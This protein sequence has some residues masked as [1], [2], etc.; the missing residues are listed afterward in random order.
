[1]TEP[2]VASEH[3]TVLAHA[4]MG[5]A[6]ERG[7]LAS[8]PVKIDVEAFIGNLA[9]RVDVPMARAVRVTIALMRTYGGVVAVGQEDRIGG[10]LGDAYVAVVE[11]VRM[12]SH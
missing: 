1:M 3:E 9:G 2:E 7:W 12:G 4:I 6:L 8:S 10:V 5:L 11:R